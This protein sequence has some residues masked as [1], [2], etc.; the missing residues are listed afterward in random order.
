[1]QRNPKFN[2]LRVIVDNKTQDQEL[3]QIIMNSVF[4]SS[5]FIDLGSNHERKK[6]TIDYG[7]IS[8]I[9]SSQEIMQKTGIKDVAKREVFFNPATSNSQ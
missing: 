5:N 3:L 4:S 1:M 9:I 7:L 6:L 8:V 2:K